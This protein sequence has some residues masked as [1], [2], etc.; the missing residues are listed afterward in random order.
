MSQGRNENE[1][2]S[3]QISCM[4]YSLTPNMKA[5]CSSE[6]LV[7]FSMDYV[8]YYPRK[9]KYV[10]LLKLELNSPSDKPSLLDHFG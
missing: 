7:D 5:I 6:T 4:A 10:L 3:K 8:V 9:Q 1:S 2:D